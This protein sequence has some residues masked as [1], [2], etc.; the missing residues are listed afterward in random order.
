VVETG[1]APDPEVFDT[2]LAD[3]GP[4]YVPK[5]AVDPSGPWS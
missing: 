5:Y 2:W 4:A 1:A 3:G